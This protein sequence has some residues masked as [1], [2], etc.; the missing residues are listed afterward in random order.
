M[1]VSPPR[2]Q[3]AKAASK[4]N[5]SLMHTCLGNLCY[6]WCYYWHYLNGKVFV[7]QKQHRFLQCVPT[8]LVGAVPCGMGGQWV[9]MSPSS[10]LGCTSG[11][12]VPSPTSV[13]ANLGSPH[14]HLHLPE[15][16]L[17]DPW[18]EAGAHQGGTHLFCIPQLKP[19]RCPAKSSS[20]GTIRGEN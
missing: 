13:C 11:V 6:C 19:P 17:Q 8:S 4:F 7:G 16:A 5:I 2:S 9:V 15:L 1:P 10:V 12:P 14:A 3:T 18:L 20:R